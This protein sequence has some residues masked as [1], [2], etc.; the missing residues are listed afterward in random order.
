MTL[1]SPC[2][3]LRCEISSLRCGV[4]RSRSRPF[5]RFLPILPFHRRASKPGGFFLRLAP[6]DFDWISRRGRGGISKR[7]SAEISTMPVKTRQSLRSAAPNRCKQRPT[8]KINP[9]GLSHADNGAHVRH[10]RTIAAKRSRTL[11]ASPRRVHARDRGC[12]AVASARIHRT[13]HAV[14]PAQHR[15]MDLAP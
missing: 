8:G 1:H 4:S 12:G 5:G 15:A 7:N 3:M 13:A 10:F 9:T 11:G 2:K 14:A 6:G